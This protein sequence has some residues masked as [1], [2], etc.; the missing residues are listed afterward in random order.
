MTTGSGK[1]YETPVITSSGFDEAGKI[2]W[3][4]PGAS[5]TKPQ[6]NEGY[7]VCY[8]NQA[9]FPMG[10]PAAASNAASK[11]ECWVDGRTS[12]A[13]LPFA[14]YVGFTG[15]L[16]FTERTLG[17]TNT[18]ELATCN[19]GVPG[20][21]GILTISLNRTPIVVGNSKIY[22]VDFIY[23]TEDAASGASDSKFVTRMDSGLQFG[24]SYPFYSAKS[25]SMSATIEER[26]TGV[27]AIRFNVWGAVPTTET[28]VAHLPLGIPAD[29]DANGK[30]NDSGWSNTKIIIWYYASGFD[31]RFREVYY[32][33][34]ITV[35]PMAV[36]TG[37]A[38]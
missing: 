24:D 23:E 35:A 27:E 7:T 9:A 21:I 34:V 19:F 6:A 20:T 32:K 18:V 38:W 15:P 30:T 36:N 22:Y 3:A 10:V 16:S 12:T 17:A 2:E 4:A 11:L 8:N 13:P 29:T 1:D 5:G 33:D 28:I 25:N 14:R 26:S 37:A 31:T